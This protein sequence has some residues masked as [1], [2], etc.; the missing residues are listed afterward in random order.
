LAP[1]IYEMAYFGQGLT[2]RCRAFSGSP[3]RNHEIAGNLIRDL[4][5]H[6][7]A[8]LLGGVRGGLALG[9]ALFVPRLSLICRFGIDLPVRY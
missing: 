9:S 6:E 7:R 8:Y 2:L 4:E 3:L 5:W 1:T